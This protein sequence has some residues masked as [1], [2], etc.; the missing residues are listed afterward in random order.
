MFSPIHKYKLHAAI[1]SAIIAVIGAITTVLTIKNIILVT[2]LL[3]IW[4]VILAAAIGLAVKDVVLAVKYAMYPLILILSTTFGFVISKILRLSAGMDRKISFLIGFVFI[5]IVPVPKAVSKLVESKYHKI[6]DNIIDKEIEVKESLFYEFD[7]E[8]YDEEYLQY[9][10]KSFQIEAQSPFMRKVRIIMGSTITIISII[11]MIIGW[12]NEDNPN[13]FYG[14]LFLGGL[15]A[16]FY[17]VS[18]IGFG[19]LLGLLIPLMFCSSMIILYLAYIFLNFIFNKSIVWGI[20]L[21]ILVVVLIIYLYILFLK[22]CSKHPFLA[23]SNKYIVKDEVIPKVK[24]PE[25]YELIDIFECEPYFSDSA[26]IPWYY[27]SLGFTLNRGEETLIVSMEPAVG[28]F[29]FK[30]YL[31]KRLLS[32]FHLENSMELRIEKIHEKEVIHIIFQEHEDMDSFYIET[33]PYISI[34]CDYSS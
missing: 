31:G 26:D 7:H 20:I 33:K 3:G 14:T 30:H 23:P 17:G 19:F 12:L 18:I 29:D 24:M 15:I 27:K 4:I 13:V 5:I 11:S 25:L 32:H 10:P 2:A 28:R 6:D 1:L 8:D 16:L 9:V 34:H 21:T 22:W